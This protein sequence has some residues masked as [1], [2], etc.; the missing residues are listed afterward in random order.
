VVGY[1][2]PVTT[3]TVD[4]TASAPRSSD[5]LDGDALRATKAVYQAISGSCRWSGA[6]AL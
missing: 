1:I 5:T 6:G 4:L 2:N 3:E